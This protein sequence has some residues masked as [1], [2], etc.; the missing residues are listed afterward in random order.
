MKAW[1]LINSL[2]VLSLALMSND[3]IKPAV[4]FDTTIRSRVAVLDT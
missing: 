1:T 4:S 3:K 2:F